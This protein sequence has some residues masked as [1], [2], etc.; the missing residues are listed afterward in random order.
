M[1]CLEIQTRAPTSKGS[2]AAKGTHESTSS[3]VTHGEETSPQ[4]EPQK[5]LCQ[6]QQR[7]R[8]EKKAHASSSVGRQQSQIRTQDSQMEAQN[9]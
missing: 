2:P 6:T 3:P 9:V 8:D 5:T 4:R 7:H 1:T